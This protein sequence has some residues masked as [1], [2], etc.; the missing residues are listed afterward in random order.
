MHHVNSRNKLIKSA[1]LCYEITKIHQ[2]RTL[3]F[4][5]IAVPEL[6]E[7]VFKQFL[8]L[9]LLHTNEKNRCFNLNWELSANIYCAENWNKN[10]R[11][12]ERTK[13]IFTQT[14]IFRNWVFVFSPKLVAEYFID[15]GI[16]VQHYSTALRVEQLNIFFKN[17]KCIF[18]TASFLLI[19]K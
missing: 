12:N 3:W 18:F 2:K 4:I 14:V 11:M 7:I 10:A 16:I 6:N 9:N 1:N 15:N 17:S 19:L 13:W 8:R 5:H